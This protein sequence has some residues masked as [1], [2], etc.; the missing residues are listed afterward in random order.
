VDLIRITQ[1]ADDRL[2]RHSI[3][4]NVAGVVLEAF[5]GGRVPPWWLPTLADAIARR[6]MVVIATRCIG[7]SLGDEY[8]YVGSYHDLLRLRTLFAPHLGGSKARIKLMVAL[9]AARSPDEVRQWFHA[10]SG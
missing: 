8:G 5:G 3:A 10:K 1:G 2:L 4:D 6:V 7:G 9:G